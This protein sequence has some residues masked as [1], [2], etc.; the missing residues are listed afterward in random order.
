MPRFSDIVDLAITK[1]NE[2]LR[3]VIEKEI[4][5]YDIMFALDKS[6]L[7]DNLVFQGGTC[8]RLCYGSHRFSE[9]LDFVGGV[10]FANAQ[11]QQIREC[12]MD[13]IGARYGLEVHV[14]DPKQMRE[15]P[16]YHGLEV[17]RWQVAVV[18][19]A[20]RSDLPTQK[21]KLEVAN[22]PAHTRVLTNL[23]R[24]YSFL[25]DSYQ[26]LLLPV[27]TMDEILADKIVSLSA[28]QSYIRYRDIW[29]IRWLSQEGA[30]ID[31]KLVEAKIRDYRSPN[32]VDALRVMRDDVKDISSSA[33]FRDEMS[34]FIDARVRGGTI[35][36]PGFGEFV[37]ERVSRVLNQVGTRIYG[38]EFD[39]EPDDFI[40]G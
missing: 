6:G 3:P 4:L 18:T 27:E 21:I 2:G 12:V 30:K 34:R 37:G 23:D 22:V 5:H 16:T 1:G 13:H 35:D 8:L 24:N 9:D 26:D 11:L 38:R 17:D 31:E 29:D 28:C 19:N 36:R 40:I 15:E 32:F 14:K 33:T 25:P 20:G 39:N 10:A 7:L